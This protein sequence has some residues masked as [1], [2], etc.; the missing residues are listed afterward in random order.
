[1]TGKNKKN[2]IKVKNETANSENFGVGLFFR[3]VEIITW[4]I[5]KK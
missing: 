2:K 4:K 1:M 5:K 3:R